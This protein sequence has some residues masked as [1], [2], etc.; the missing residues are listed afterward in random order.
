MFTGRIGIVLAILGLLLVPCVAGGIEVA[1]VATGQFQRAGGLLALASLLFGGDLV[2]LILAYA[3]WIRSSRL[4]Q[5]SNR[6]LQVGHMA[7]WIVVGTLAVLWMGLGIWQLWHPFGLP[8]F[9]WLGGGA[10]SPLL[11]ILPLTLL[12]I[13][14]VLERR[15]RE[16][17]NV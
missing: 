2:L 3:P 6:W 15:A 12:L 10:L 16:R 7:L 17:R 8:D 1:F 9:F 4:H 11:L 5:L 14:R 13:G